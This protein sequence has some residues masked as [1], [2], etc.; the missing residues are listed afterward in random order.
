MDPSLPPLPPEHPYE[1]QNT[2]SYSSHDPN[3]PEPP[4]EDPHTA[5]G[6]VAAV[7]ETIKRVLTGPSKFFAGMHEDRS[8][9]AAVILALTIICITRVIG[10]LVSMILMQ[11]FP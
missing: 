9:T 2:W 4:I 3:E 5:L 6:T 10:L 11:L 1:P 7:V 8:A